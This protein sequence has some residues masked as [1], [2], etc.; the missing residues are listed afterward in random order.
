MLDGHEGSKSA[1][2]SH[3]IENYK[4]DAFIQ[5]CIHTGFRVRSF[6]FVLHSNL[7]LEARNMHSGQL[8]GCYGDLIAAE[9]QASVPWVYFMFIL[10]MFQ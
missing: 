8:L 9:T 7:C 10:C 1:F 6:F 3:S 5:M 4:L 2:D